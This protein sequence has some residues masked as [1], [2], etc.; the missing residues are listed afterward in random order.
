MPAKDIDAIFDQQWAIYRKI[1]EADYMD[2]S[3][4]S[5]ALAN[6]LH[7]TGGSFTMLDLGCGDTEIS[8]KLVSAGRCRSF[9]GVDSSSRALEEAA[10]RSVW[11]EIDASWVASDLLDFIKTD[12]TRYD[13]ILAGFSVHHFEKRQK[14][15]VLNAVYELLADQG[16]FFL[17]DVFLLP[18]MGRDESTERYLEWIR[19]EWELITAEEYRLIED[20][21]LAADFPESTN[22]MMEAAGSAGFSECV[23]LPAPGNE[24]HQVMVFER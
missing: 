1:I 17:Y 5:K 14:R 6:Q 4:I 18:G 3:L 7:V 22:W 20:H 10:Q 11:E 16:R 12:T 24:F 21:I 8:S 2:H 9:K 15:E 13:M 23:I 19:S